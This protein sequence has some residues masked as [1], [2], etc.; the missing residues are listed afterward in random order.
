ML[1]SDVETGKP[2]LTSD[3]NV[4]QTSDRTSLLNPKVS[5]HITSVGSLT[6]M[7]SFTNVNASTT[8]ND[9]VTPHPLPEPI[10]QVSETPKVGGSLTRITHKS[11]HVGI[12]NPF[13]TQPP[14]HPYFDMNLDE[15]RSIVDYL[16]DMSA[17]ERTK[18]NRRSMS[19]YPYKQW[20]D[21]S[22]VPQGN[23]E[24]MIPYI[25]H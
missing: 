10:P 16:P 8:V 22:V 23:D 5:R 15:S 2:S 3:I 18:W 20:V 14:S 25:F 6:H 9:D 21:G 13:P 1:T 7:P 12:Y 11:S 24:L 4:N 17:R 19:N